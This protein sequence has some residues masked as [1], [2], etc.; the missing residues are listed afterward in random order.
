[1]EYSKDNLEVFAKQFENCSHKKMVQLLYQALDDS[2]Y[3]INRLCE[4][5]SK[6][7]NFGDKLRQDSLLLHR[8][9]FDDYYDIAKTWDF[10]TQQNISHYINEML[11]TD[12]LFKRKKK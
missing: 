5:E 11:L 3:N 10:Q 8:Y 9:E 12:E 1:M 7:K 6:I 4:L 2:I